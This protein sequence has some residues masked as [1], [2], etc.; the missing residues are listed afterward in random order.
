MNGIVMDWD[1]VSAVDYDTKV[2]LGDIDPDQVALDDRIAEW[3]GTYDRCVN[4]VGFVCVRARNSA[5]HVRSEW[6]EVKDGAELLSL[7]DNGLAD[8]SEVVGI[9]EIDWC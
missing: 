5:G 4:S 9:S 8:G 7:W 2:A 3:Q 6:V 1:S